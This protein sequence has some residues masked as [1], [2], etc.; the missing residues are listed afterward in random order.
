MRGFS[1]YKFLGV[2]DNSVTHLRT[3]NIQRVH[4]K[5]DHVDCVSTKPRSAPKQRPYPNPPF[6]H[7]QLHLIVQQPHLLSRLERR[8]PNIRTPI[9][10]EGIAEGAIPATAHLPLHREIHLGQIV[11][12]QFQRVEGVVGRAALRRVF[13]FD[14]LLQPAGAVFAGAAALAGFGAAFGRW[15]GRV[16]C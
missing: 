4:P 7:L 3:K 9:A 11:G 10:P 6:Q 15:G 14:L 5:G 2:A 13:G 16:R 8:Q 1:R 12:T